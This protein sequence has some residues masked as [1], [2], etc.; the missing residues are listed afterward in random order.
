MSS[1]P[2]K[3]LKFLRTQLF[4]TQEALGNYFGLT[5]HQINSYEIG[6]ANVPAELI[7]KLCTAFKLSRED[8]EKAD[9]AST[10]ADLS[11]INKDALERTNETISDSRVN[12]WR[13]KYYTVLEKYN[14][15]L[16]E[17]RKYQK[18]Q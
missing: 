5:R 14:E 10:Q 12:E 11:G 1:L 17:L 9:L 4:L 15:A 6:R 13:E 7:E 3:N 8:F 16:E 18:E 2:A